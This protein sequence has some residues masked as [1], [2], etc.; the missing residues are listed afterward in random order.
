VGR[1]GRRGKVR[2]SDRESGRV[3]AGA[4]A[5]HALS[6]C[7]KVEKGKEEEGGGEEETKGVGRERVAE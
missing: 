4:A 6:L 7:G 3:R 1:G 5:S 2:F